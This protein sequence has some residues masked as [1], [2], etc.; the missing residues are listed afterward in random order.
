MVVSRLYGDGDSDGDGN[1]NGDGD[2]DCSYCFASIVS[3]WTP[4]SSRTDV[5]IE[6]ELYDAGLLTGEEF[7]SG[8]QS[9]KRRKRPAKRVQK[10][11]SGAQKKRRYRLTNVHMVEQYDWLRENSK[12]WVMEMV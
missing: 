9:S 7:E 3:S 10:Q 8:H 4:F 2:G 12:Q 11:R 5:E 6:R 1:G